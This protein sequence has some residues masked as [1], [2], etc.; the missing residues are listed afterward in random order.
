MIGD[1]FAKKGVIG[2]AKKGFNEYKEDDLLNVSNTYY[3]YVAYYSV[4][5]IAYQCTNGL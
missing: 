1:R 5:N 2:F 4:V 3:A